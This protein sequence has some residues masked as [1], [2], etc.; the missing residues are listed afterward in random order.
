MIAK[1]SLN[2]FPLLWFCT[3]ARYLSIIIFFYFCGNWD[4][5]QDLC[6]LGKC[7]TTDPHPQLSTIVLKK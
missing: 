7:S 4:R 3:F 5:T 6:M 2:I 1:T